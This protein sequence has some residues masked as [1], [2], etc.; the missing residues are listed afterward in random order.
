MAIVP[1]E[2]SYNEEQFFAMDSAQTCERGDLAWLNTDDARKAYSFT[3]DTDEATT[4][5]KFCA[6]FLGVFLDR[7]ESGDTDEV[8]VLTDGVVEMPCTSTTYEHGDMF[9][10]EKDASGN[11]L[12]SDKLQKVTNPWEAIGYA[13]DRKGSA[14]TK[15]KLKLWPTAL[16]GSLAGARVVDQPF[17]TQLDLTAAN[18]PSVTNW[19]FP[20]RCKI[21]AIKGVVE[22]TVAADTTAPVISFL[23]GSNE[24]DDTLTIPDG[25]AR[26]AFVSQAVSD[27]NGYDYFDVDDQLDLKVKTAAADSSS[28]AGAA[29][30]VLRLLKY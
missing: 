22:T 15:V 9:G 2:K 26:G 30:V 25:T 13:V 18:D 17:P 16:R 27:A 12:D 3:W 24:G 20:W 11:Y 7:S 21:L 1:V 10:P 28:A 6:K 29:H 5:A 23:N 19:L 4:R 14:D 8:R